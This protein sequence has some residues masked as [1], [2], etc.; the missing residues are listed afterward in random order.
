[1]TVESDLNRFYGILDVCS[2]RV[3]G[4]RRLV[5]CSARLAWPERGIYFFF[6]PDERRSGQNHEHR[7]VVRIGTHAVSAGSQTSLWRRLH[8]H[9]GNGKPG[10]SAGGNHRASVFRRHAGG[11]LSR[12]GR[13]AGEASAT[14]GTGSSAAPEIVA[15]EEPL[16]RRVSEWLGALP[17]LWIEADDEPGADSVRAYVERNCIALVSQGVVFDP[18]S[19]EWLG[20]HAADDMIRSSGLWNVK[21]VGS[22]YDPAFLSVLS[23]LVEGRFTASPRPM[24]HASQIPQTGRM[25]ADWTVPHSLALISCTKKKAT[26]A[27]RA[28]ELYA[29]SA[30]F[31]KAYELA[32]RVTQQ[33]LILSAKHGLV[34]PSETLAPYEQTLAGAS[35]ADRRRWAELVFNQLREAP[36]YQAST[37]VVWFAG[38]S[39]RGE[40]LPLVQRDGK[41]CVVP[42]EGLA[43]GEQLAW[44]NERLS[45]LPLP[46][47]R[48]AAAPS[49]REVSLASPARPKAI[50]P[51][52]GAPTAD[53]F[54]R[55]LGDQ[56]ARAVRG[57]KVVLSLSSGDLHRLVGGY[58][59][60][61]HRM[62][63]CCSVMRSEM[64]SGDQIVSEP[65]KGAGASLVISYKLG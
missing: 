62:P 10:E 26:R 9:R 11:A 29:P 7:R 13:F 19:P 64:R 17:F 41:A 20:R 3:G 44:L 38:D 4:P 21:H 27:C 15:R 28:S 18:P 12:S 16:E 6:E 53:D 23:D 58:P 40:L 25:S 45:G 22:D 5:D 52:G 30:F 43:Q 46:V 39:Y 14:W 2:A 42:M 37:T 49:P 55:V 59:G 60:N 35:L 36:E 24:S 56:K 33:T 47:V 8:Q 48:P 31:S 34:R 50:G 57:G 65:P 61:N 51:R 63:V 54:R 32:G 1:M